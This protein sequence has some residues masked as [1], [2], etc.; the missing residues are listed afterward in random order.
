M[1]GLTQLAG[2]IAVGLRLESPKVDQSADIAAFP[3][4]V[5]GLVD[6]L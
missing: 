4:I 6:L 3:H 5:E 2:I 1:A